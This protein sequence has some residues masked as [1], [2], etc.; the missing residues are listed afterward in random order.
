MTEKYNN[1]IC[2]GIEVTVLSPKA[3]I[4]AAFIK[5]VSQIALKEEKVKNAVLTVI[6]SGDAA[7]R[8]LN[9]KYMSKDSTTDVLSFD[10]KPPFL[11][12][13]C[14]VADVVVSVDR[15]RSVARKIK[16]SFKEELARYIIHGILHL[17]GYDDSTPDERRRMWMRQEELLKKIIGFKCQVSRKIPKYPKRDT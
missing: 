9:R 15:A 17:T 13:A 5:S 12:K 7:L 10:L 8:R 6:L 2:K 4:L 14:L 3:R 1:S 16:V 11:S